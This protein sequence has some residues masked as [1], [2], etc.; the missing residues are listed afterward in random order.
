MDGIWMICRSWGVP[1]SSMLGPLL[2]LIYI[3][4]LSKE[5]S[6]NPRLY[7]DDTSLLSVIRDTNLSADALS[8]DLL[9]ENGNVKLDLI[10]I[11]LSKLKKLF[12]LKLRNQAIRY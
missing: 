4:D 1:Q 12:F 5:L 3:N 7:S 10:L 11:L 8:N 6:S 9:M 2:F